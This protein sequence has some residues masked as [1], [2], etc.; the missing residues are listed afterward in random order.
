M[1]NKVDSD[2]NA[3]DISQNNNAGIESKRNDNNSGN[4]NEN[5]DE[6]NENINNNNNNGDNNNDNSYSRK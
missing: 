1:F 2:D 4:N 5:N 6:Y 3:A